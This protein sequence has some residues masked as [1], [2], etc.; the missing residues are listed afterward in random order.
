MSTVTDIYKA[1]AVRINYPIEPTHRCMQKIIGY[2]N[3]LLSLSNTPQYIVEVKLDGNPGKRYYNK[4]NE[5]IAY[6][7]DGSPAQLNPDGTIN[8]KDSTAFVI[9]SGLFQDNNTGFQ[10]NF[11]T[12]EADILTDD[13]YLQPILTS[14]FLVLSGV[15]PSE[16]VMYINDACTRSTAKVHTQQ[17]NLNNIKRRL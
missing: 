7:L 13:Y 11:V 2:L 1:L 5:K 12:S 15:S 4:R 8:T 3:L 14:L 10:K 6:L 17:V 9:R 16:A